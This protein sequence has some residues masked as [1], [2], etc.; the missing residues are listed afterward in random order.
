M[1]VSQDP[2]FQP[3]AR[4]QLPWLYVLARRLVG[5]AAEDVVQDCLI[6]A[7]R[8]FE[9]L[10]DPAAAPA[11]FRSILLNCA[12]DHFR[13][14]AAGIDETPMED[15]P[16]TS[17]YRRIV[18]EDPWPYSDSVHV[19]FLHSF[20]EQDVWEVLDR[21]KPMYR[22]PLVLVHMEGLAVQEVA[23]MLGTPKNT[24][25]SW[26]HRGRKNFEAELWDY[27]SESGLLRER[28]EAQK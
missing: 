17:L 28:E 4:Q 16:A 5:D 7:Y 19:D 18:D 20:R 13:R 3:V 23:R 24:V 11:W 2:G 9:A 1:A 27:A 8:N 15:V 21:L 22:I 26:L 25:L 12:R 6:K 14:G 10:R